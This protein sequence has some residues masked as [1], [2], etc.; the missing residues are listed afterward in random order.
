MATYRKFP[1]SHTTMTVTEIRKSRGFYT[2][3][4]NEADAYAIMRGDKTATCIDAKCHIQKGDWLVFKVYKIGSSM[5]VMHEIE[6]LVF[7]VTHVSELGGCTPA[8]N[9]ACFVKKDGYTFHDG[10]VNSEYKE[11]TVTT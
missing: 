4:L 11:D 3:T 8:M 5:R 6:D 7:E 2:C 1:P 10:D 9:L